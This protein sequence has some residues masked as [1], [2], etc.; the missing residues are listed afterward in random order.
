MAVTLRAMNS[1]RSAKTSDARRY[2][3]EVRFRQIR[4]LFEI[5]KHGTF[6]AAS[7]SLGMA[8][9]SVWRQVRALEDDYGVQLVFAK[10]HDVRLTEDGE[11]LLDL[12]APLV[13]GFDSLKKVFQ[14]QHG[15]AERHLRVAAPATMLNSPMRHVIAHYRET[16]PQVR[17]SLIDAPSRIAWQLLEAEK[18]DLAVVGTPHGVVIP[19]RFEATPLVRY[20]FEVVCLESHPFAKIKAPKLR[21]IVKQPLILA[22][23]DSSSRMQFD[24]LIAKAG[25]SDQVNVIMT[26]GNVTSILNYVALGMGI[27]VLTRPATQALH[28]PTDLNAHFIHRDVS[29]FLGYDHVALLH[30]KGRHELSHV[31]VFR[32]MVMQGLRAE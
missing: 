14:D 7:R 8:T 11:R 27:A 1:K 20:P 21:D 31:R 18:A 15:K 10:G 13:E 9:P 30:P 22:G 28:V 23:E 32:E 6:A 25:L 5:A 16:H 26:A 17:L 19:T 24:H 2:F 29:N 4:A 12:A 3:K